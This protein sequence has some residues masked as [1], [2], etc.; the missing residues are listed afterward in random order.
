ML[1]ELISAGTKILGGFLGQN[2]A[3]KAREAQSQHIAQQMALQKEFAKSGIRWRVEDA[4]RAGI[5][6]IY[7]L[8]SSGA[9]YT[10]VSANFAA[11][12]SVPSAM[13]AAGQDLGR[14]INAT[15]SG[16]ER[17]DA[18]T[19]AAQALTLEKGS[20]ENEVL[21]LE[22][23]SKTAR[24]RQQ[25]NP[26]MPISDNWLIPGQAETLVAPKDSPLERVVSAP[27][28]P[29]QE[30]AA[31]GDVGFAR[32]KTGYAPVPSKDVK[33]RIEDNLIQEV[34]W[35]VRN[36]IMPS[37]GFYD[38]PKFKPDEGKKWIYNPLRQEYQQWRKPYRSVGDA[39]SG[40]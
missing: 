10:P 14:A 19:K 22:L 29:H 37:L 35:A 5:H 34:M 26:A 30:H 24:L 17:V 38:P 9:S 33:E 1:G 11:D 25:T 40:W 18:F 15:R 16:T 2:E 36:N 7:A 31:I 23:A 4:K 13:A 12:T 6:P 3:E 27:G 39:K 32:T 21:R 20:L 8:G 28:A